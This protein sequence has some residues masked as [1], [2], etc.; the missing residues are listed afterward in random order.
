MNQ[1]SRKLV[2]VAAGAEVR[3][4]V[5]FRAFFNPEFRC[6]R[7]GSGLVLRHLLNHDAA[8]SL[9]GGPTWGS[10]PHTMGCCLRVGTLIVG[11]S[12]RPQGG[13]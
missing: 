11:T 10:P 6:L 3:V 4:G 1:P 5:P 13:R 9:Y 7:L 2:L 12:I 8:V